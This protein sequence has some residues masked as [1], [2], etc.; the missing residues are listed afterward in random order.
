MSA[1]SIA[2]D[3]YNTCIVKYEQTPNADTIMQQW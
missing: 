2:D 3:K 1:E